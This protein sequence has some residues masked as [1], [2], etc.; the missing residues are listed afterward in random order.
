MTILPCFVVKL[1]MT[2]GCVGLAKD[3]YHYYEELGRT[4]LNKA[5]PALNKM[6]EILSN[7]DFYGTKIWNPDGTPTEKAKEILGHLVAQFEPFS[8]RGLRE[9]QKRQSGTP[10]WFPFVGLTPAPK[11]LY[12]TEAER[13][14]DELTAER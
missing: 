14:M 6:G 13:M 10:P 11:A 7:R 12:K 9:E 5:Y 3:I 1:K 4:A 2:P 8:V